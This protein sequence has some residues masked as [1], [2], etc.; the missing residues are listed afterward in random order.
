MWCLLLDVPKIKEEKKDFYEVRYGNTSQKVTAEDEHPPSFLPGQ[1]HVGT[2]HIHTDSPS[3][4]LHSASFIIAQASLTFITRPAS[5]GFIRFQRFVHYYGG[6]ECVWR[7]RWCVCQHWNTVSLVT[8][9]L[10]YN[11]NICG[12]DKSFYSFVFHSHKLS[13]TLPQ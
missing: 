4:P 10:H 12:M 1:S 9:K 8:T 7:G 2:I 5:P 3:V 6:D 11:E 13:H